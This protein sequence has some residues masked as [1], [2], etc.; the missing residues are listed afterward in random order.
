MVFIAA[1]IRRGNAFVFYQ[2]KSPHF[3]I[4][5][6]GV[7]FR[8]STFL[9][10]WVSE[11]DDLRAGSLKQQVYCVECGSSV[12]CANY[13]SQLEIPVEVWVERYENA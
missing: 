2:I 11:L 6:I 7:T 3:L 5:E 9:G 10:T 13:N 8:Y 1:R 12:C 4:F